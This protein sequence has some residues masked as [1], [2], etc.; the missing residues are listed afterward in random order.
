MLFIMFDQIL[1]KGRVQASK[2]TSDNMP[3]S[4]CSGHGRL[5]AVELE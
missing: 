5:C 1:M 3:E 4:I 2:I